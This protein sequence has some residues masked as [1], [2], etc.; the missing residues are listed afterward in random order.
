MENTGRMKHTMIWMESIKMR[1]HEILM[2]MW[3]VCS[4]LRQC[5]VN[6]VLARRPDETGNNKEGLQW[7]Y[8]KLGNHTSRGKLGEERVYYRRGTWVIRG[9]GENSWLW[10][11]AC[12]EWSYSGKQEL[13]RGSNVYL[14]LTSGTLEVTSPAWPWRHVNVCVQECDVISPQ[15]CYYY[16]CYYYHQYY[17]FCKCKETHYNAVQLYLHKM[18][19]NCT[20]V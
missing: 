1:T 10:V 16:Y 15:V 19:A 12:G 2:S 8:S 9:K 17:Y 5:P 14:E 6:V 7:L 3:T 18:H 4:I 11:W 13:C 20:L